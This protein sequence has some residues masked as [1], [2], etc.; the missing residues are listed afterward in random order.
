MEI[1]ANLLQVVLVCVCVYVCAFEAVCAYLLH[2][3]VY[4]IQDIEMFQCGFKWFLLC[5]QLCL[6]GVLISECISTTLLASSSVFNL[7]L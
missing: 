2:A 6:F 7:G 3:Y 1:G 5:V 4:M